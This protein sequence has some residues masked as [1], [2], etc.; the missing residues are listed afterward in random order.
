MTTEQRKILETRLNENEVIVNLLTID[1]GEDERGFPMFKH[2][3]ETPPLNYKLVQIIAPYNVAI[4]ENLS[5]EPATT[6]S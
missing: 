4:L 6:I 1:N 3:Y 5:Y 2:V